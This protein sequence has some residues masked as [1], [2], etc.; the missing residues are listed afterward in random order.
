M[1]EINS[2]CYALFTYVYKLL[3][4]S[5]GEGMELCP[6]TGLERGMGFYW[7]LNLEI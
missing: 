3:H 1:Q 6:E 2:L 7:V 5:K 4:K